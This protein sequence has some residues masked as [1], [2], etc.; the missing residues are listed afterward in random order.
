MMKKLLMGAVA[1]AAMQAVPV[2]AQT[3]QAQSVQI[4]V[5]GTVGSKCSTFSLDPIS[6]TAISTSNSS[7]F[8]TG[9]DTSSPATASVWCNKAGAQV[10][11]EH[12]A[13]KANTVT[14]SNAAFTDTVDF[15][16]TVKLGT[17]TIA[18]GGTTVGIVADTLTVS[19][20][21]NATTA[22]PVADSY[23]G[24]IKV[25]LTPGV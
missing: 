12:V 24:T 6:F 10:S 18:S 19:A 3:G 21:T 8:A 25:T 4:D 1:L 7:G 2:L 5:T 11:Y 9:G 20:T 15:T 14:T 16:P 13:M 17:T 23:T 22:I